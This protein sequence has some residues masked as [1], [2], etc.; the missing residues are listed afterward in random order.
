MP[1]G[2]GRGGELEGAVCAYVCLCACM[3]LSLGS[4]EDILMKTFE[5]MSINIPV[6][7]LS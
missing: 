2:M 7:H 4:V 1:L 5:R 6:W 3:C